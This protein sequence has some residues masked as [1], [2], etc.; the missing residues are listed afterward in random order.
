MRRSGAVRGAASTGGGRAWLAVAAAAIVVTFAVQLALAAWNRSGETARL[1]LTGASLSLPWPHESQEGEP[2]SLGLGA[3]PAVELTG[4]ELAALGLPFDRIQRWRT[5]GS[6]RRPLAHSLWVVLDD[7]AEAWEQYLRQR[8]EAFE[9][10]QRRGGERKWSIEREREA[11]ARLRQSPRQP[12]IIAAG[13]DAGELRRRFPDPTLQAVA[14]G[15][16]TASYDTRLARWVGHPRLAILEI[17]V[18]P[19]L[20]GR[21][22]ALSELR[23][24][25][26]G[27]SDPAI[28]NQE[29]GFR[30]VV[31]WGRRREPWLVDIHPVV[32]RS[33]S[34]AAPTA[35]PTAP[36]PDRST[37]LLSG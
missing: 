30:A 12:V 1:E 2:L 33:S 10:L 17:A 23:E 19:A 37:D 5:D 3:I 35:T 34:D 15:T 11:L 6:N 27:G 8:E 9:R 20:H 26:N 4:E 18:P 31:S 32:G 16:V 28:A 29:P 24:E 25:R 36:P 13:G 21:V 14:R 7:S 22:R